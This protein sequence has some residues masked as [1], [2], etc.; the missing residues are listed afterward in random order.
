[1]ITAV[2]T[3]GKQLAVVDWHDARM[4]KIAQYGR[5]IACRPPLRDCRRRTLRKRHYRVFATMCRA[6]DVRGI[7]I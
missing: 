1:M 2:A 6:I 3:G 4:R 7:I 5:G